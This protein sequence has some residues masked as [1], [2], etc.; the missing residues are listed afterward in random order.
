[1][2][3]RV[4]KPDVLWSYI[5]QVFNIGSGILI[6][7][8]V[9]RLL[10]T[11]EI[12]MNYLMMTVG[13]MVALIDFGFAPQFGR[14]FSYVFSG[15]QSLKKE[16]LE[17]DAGDQINYRLL[18]NLIDVAK[19][20]YFYMSIIVLMLMLTFG[21]LYIYIITDGF[22]LVHNSFFVWL[23]YTV[24]TFFNIYFYY[25]SSLLYGRGLI[26]EEKKALMASRIV[27]ILLAA[28][29]LLLGAGLLGLCL[30]NLLSPFAGRYLSYKYFFDHELKSRIDQYKTTK[31]ELRE[32]FFVLLY[33]A[34][35]M[36][37]NFIGAYAITKF[38]MFIAGLYLSLTEISSYGLMLQLVTIISGISGTFY[39]SMFPHLTSLVLS[40]DYKRLIAD[41]SWTMNVFYVIFILL[42]FGLMILGPI[43]L[44]F[45]GSNAQLPSVHI[46]S[47][48]LIVTLLEQNHSLFAM[49]I[50]A[51]NKVPFVNAGLV[52]GFFI[53]VGDFLIL[54]YTSFGLLGIVFVQGIV[55]ICYNNWFWPRY[56]CRGLGVAFYQFILIGCQESIKR[57]SVYEKKV[58]QY[59]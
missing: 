4:T 58:L 48:F 39:T 37:I 1:M 35:K 28:I 15:A 38:G 5:A 24:S 27:Y 34:K 16:G 30:A 50:T 17:N 42:S 23:S 44:V 33:N 31:A 12:A 9:L 46:L 41:F 32:L 11:D 22:T 2:D 8:F 19:R 53:C 59:F 40:K 54:H 56:V 36:G 26:K 47:L 3:I 6:L 13:T 18:K 52:S 10:S 51:E 14:N 43:V 7:P 49:Q 55:Q 57:L 29:L 20:V 45:I 25:Y 21:S